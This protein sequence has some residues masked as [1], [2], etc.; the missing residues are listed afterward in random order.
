MTRVHNQSVKI[1]LGLFLALQA[2]YF[3]LP[4]LPITLPQ[5]VEILSEYTVIQENNLT[6]CSAY[7]GN[8]DFKNKIIT[9]CS[10]GDSA[11][12]RVTLLHELVHII[13]HRIGIET[14][15]PLEQFVEYRAHAAFQEIYGLKGSNATQQEAPVQ[16]PPDTPQIPQ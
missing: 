7:W 2:S 9:I 14:G 8:T 1:F 3:G 11:D 15:G 10:R 16:T 6:Y 13:Y 12:K 5:V 4:D